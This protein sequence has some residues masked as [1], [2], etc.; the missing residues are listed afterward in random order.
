MVVAEVNEKL[1][2]FLASV[3]KAKKPNFT[4]LA[5]HDMPVG[6]GR[7]GGQ[8]PQKR[9]KH[10]PP[11]SRTDRITDVTQAASG[12]GTNISQSVAV[13]LW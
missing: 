1:S 12:N 4:H 2:E 10:P 9:K 5:V 3:K 11:K 7:K 8:A 6:C 13:V